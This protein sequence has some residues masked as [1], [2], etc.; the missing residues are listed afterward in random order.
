[1]SKSRI[2]YSSHGRRVRQR[3]GRGVLG[4]KGKCRDELY[5]ERAT[6]IAC[7]SL[8]GALLARRDLFEEAYGGPVE[9]DPLERWGSTEPRSGVNDEAQ[10]LARRQIEFL[11]V[12]KV[13]IFR[14]FGRACPSRH[15]PPTV[16]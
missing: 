3:S 16:S 15:E 6:S 14:A 4:F 1:M 10:R 5:I 8:F 9:R 12:V 13:P 7:D 2:A 11:F